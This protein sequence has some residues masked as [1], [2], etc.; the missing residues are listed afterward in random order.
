MYHSEAFLTTSQCTFLAAIISTRDHRQPY[1]GLH[2]IT[3]AP[4][5]PTT[6]AMSSRKKVLVRTLDHAIQ[7]GYL[8]LSDILS[9]G[10]TDAIDLLDLSGR[11][12]S[13][14]LAEIRTIAYVR[15]FN[16]NDTQNP[17]NLLRRTFLARPRT[18]GLWIRLTF[19]PGDMLEGLAPLDLALLDHLLTDHGLFVIP[20]DIRSNTQ[21]LFVP[22][23]AMIALQLLAVITTPSKPKPSAPTLELQLPL[24]DSESL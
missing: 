14:P 22:R 4:P 17:E 12:R 16:L 10:T 18:E 24:P 9:P 11:I 7:A 21:R 8:P 23:T 15:D 2:R 3:S 19:G 1:G 6:A 20:P 5:C 13:I